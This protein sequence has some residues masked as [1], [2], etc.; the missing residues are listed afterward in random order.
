MRK[1]YFALFLALVLSCLQGRSYAQTTNLADCNITVPVITANGDTSFCI[2]EQVTLSVP[3]GY[4]SYSWNPGGATTSSITATEPGDYTVTVT[5][6]T[7]CQL[8]SGITKVAAAAPILY[9]DQNAATP[10]DGSSWANALATFSDAV[11]LA[12]NVSCVSEIHVA[13]G[14]Y[15]PTSDGNRDSTFTF[16]RGGL[17]VY[18]GYPT[19][20]G[21][22]NIAA[23]PTILS[24]DIGTPG[25]TVDNSFH[26]AAIV[27][28]NAASDSLVIDGFSFQ[29]GNADSEQEIA[30][31]NGEEILQSSGGAILAMSNAD[32]DKLLLANCRFTNN[33]ALSSAGAIMALDTRMTIRRS[34]FAD[35]TADAGGAIVIATDVDSP[36]GLLVVENCVFTSNTCAGLGGAIVAVQTP[37]EIINSVFNSNSAGELGGALLSQYE[38]VTIT[39]SVFENNRAQNGG[40]ILKFFGQLNFINNTFH[41]N[42]AY[43]DGGVLFAQAVAITLYNNILWNN[44]AGESRTAHFS[45]F[46]GSITASNNIIQGAPL[47]NGD[48]S[49]DPLFVNPA[50]P[51]GADL[52]F[53]TSDD[54]LRLQLCSPAVNA[55]NGTYLPSG[56]TT[57]LSGGARTFGGGIDIGA[58]EF[59]GNESG[60]ELLAPDDASSTQ[61]IAS[62]EA[63]VLN[64]NGSECQ[65]IATVQSTGAAPVAGSVTAKVWIES[66]QPGQYVKRHYEIMPAG[67]A[68]SATARVTLYATD[69]EFNAFNAQS[70][71]PAILLPQSTDEAETRAAR[72]ANLRIEKRSGTSSDNSGLPNSYDASGTNIDPADD[73]IVWNAVAQRWEISFDVTGFSGFFI[74]TQSSPLP[75]HW[76]SISAS[77]NTESL[78]VITWKVQETDVAFYSVQKSLDARRFETIGR[79]EGY[80]DGLHSYQFSEADI[81]KGNAYYR[82]S[83]TDTDG[84]TTFSRIVTLNSENRLDASS[85]YPIPARNDVFIEVK[86]AANEGCQVT[87]TDLSGKDLKVQQ[88]KTGAN[89]VDVSGLKTGIYLLRTSR[90]E[91]FKIIKE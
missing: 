31:Y 37:V 83:Q 59:Q 76:V 78:P 17:K 51:A 64:A 19:G 50:Q 30:T 8:T 10:G 34:Y 24:G 90:G 21:T 89:K 29:Y 74:K 36:A 55:G 80:G 27:G 44:Q 6:G 79:V 49:P 25:G 91:I 3:E 26:I 75:V 71:A 86:S 11:S 22:R 4:S 32:F 2:G 14:T 16:Y 67:D 38:D 82:I 52:V 1:L 42:G 77:M 68:A 15:Y 28:L 53:G 7:G 9:V 63:A 39:G 88:L 81:L 33:P 72:I 12:K 13:Q 73:A 46:S 65:I 56:I 20:G 69:E 62:G 47:D 66:T 61:N 40:A 5:D 58:Y 57:D 87:L 70:P 48:D 35:N 45:I 23:N 18:G 85:V 43:N 41:S 60:S 84:T 54:G